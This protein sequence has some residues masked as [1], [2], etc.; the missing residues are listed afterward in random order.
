MRLIHVH[1]TTHN[2][3]TMIIVLAAR[4]VANPMPQLRPYGHQSIAVPS[5]ATQPSRAHTKYFSSISHRLPASTRCA[6]PSA[7]GRE[8]DARG[9]RAGRGRTLGLGSTSQTFTWS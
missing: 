7:T 9:G 2:P 5:V 3:P 1:A 4:Y 6:R 8:R